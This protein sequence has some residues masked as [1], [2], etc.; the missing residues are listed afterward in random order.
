MNTDKEI[1]VALAGN[2]N[3]GKTSIF[4]S[5]VGANQKVGNFSGVTVEK[6]S[7][8]KEYNGYTIT[9]VDLP[10][11][12]SLTAYSP[13]E[14]VAR[15]FII[16]EKP[17]LIVNVVD[18]TNLERN[19]FLTTQLMDLECKMIVALNMSDEIERKN[20]S[21][22]TN[23]LNRLL[24]APT[25][26]TSAAKKTGIDELLDK[27]IKIK[28]GELETNTHKLFYSDNLEEQIE[29]IKQTIDSSK[30]LNGKYNARWLSIKLLEND[31][32]VYNLMRENPVWIKINPILSEAITR[33]ENKF[34][35]EP[36]M[37]LT[38]ERYSLI[39]G[40]IKETV[41]YPP[42]KKKSKTEFVDS[43][44]IN[45]I[46]GLPIFLF[47]MWSIFQLT[48]TL[49]DYPMGL[50]EDLFAFLGDSAA[51]LISN[52]TAQS[53]VVDGIIAGVG[54]VLVF[55]PNILI[56]FLC[57]SIMEGTGYMA[58]AA[59]VVDKIMHKFG[60]H[61]KS[62]IPMITGFGCSVPAFMAT[63]TLKSESDRITTMLIIP[64][65]SCSAKFPVYVLITGAFFATKTAGNVLFGIYIFGVG[66]ALLSAKLFKKT[67]FDDESEPFVMELP[68]YRVPTL[69][70]LIMQ[71]WFK[72][73]L[74][75]RKA[76]T[77]IL[78]ASVLI[79]IS[80]NYPANEEVAQQYDNQIAEVQS[81]N[82]LSDE[83]KEEQIAVIEN[84]KLKSKLEYSAAGYIG[85]FVEPFFAPLGFDWRLSISLINGFA[86]KEIVVSTMATIYALGDADESSSALRASLSND[87]SYTVATALAL[88][89][90][91]LLYIPCFAATVV[92]H[93]ESGKWKWTLLYGTY[94]VVIAWVMAFI[95][96][97]ISSLF[98]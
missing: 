72:A 30:H 32:I 34:D 94:S 66:I 56:L 8:K 23:Q 45:R 61:G 27:I 17:D 87:P 98:L 39:R 78:F 38:E 29:K 85:K 64:F 65:M 3:S 95:V 60:L 48:F 46:T 71:M 80:T 28:K 73:A 70:T 68:P 47:F 26:Q 96:Y 75:L 76:G 9:F 57:L 51:A 53:I 10:G 81:N 31:K 42:K 84:N 18:S 93:K 88:M 86:A 5:L 62:F 40:A 43:I 7:G 91:V 50:I 15:N 16:E 83:A 67:I 59:F 19:L 89:I 90:F 82:Q 92:F 36:E 33:F 1:L 55:L 12:Y 49:G 41:T 25:V 79:W 97:N 13:E 22:D 54:G 63:R 11:T 74:Y 6:Y 52:P 77:I 4:N 44:L 69:K 37:L 24:G 21:I 20:I 2:P 58:R 35:S 14:V